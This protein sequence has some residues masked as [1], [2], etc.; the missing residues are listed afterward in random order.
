MAD[1]TPAQKPYRELTPEAF[2]FGIGLGMLMTAAFVYI[3]LKLGFSMPGSTVA[4]ILGFAVL[5]GV[6]RKGTIVEN[7][8]NQTIASAVNNASAGVAF[9]L[10][11][12]FILSLND[13]SVR[14]E[15]IPAL[16]AAI[17]GSFLGIIFIIPLRKQMIEFDRLKF[18]TGIAVAAILKAPGAAARQAKLLAGGFG[19]AAAF[20][21]LTALHVIP[22]EYPMGVWLGLP[23]H[24]PIAVGI[25]FAIVGAGLLAGKGGLPFVFGG[26][27]AWWVVSPIAVGQ[28][29]VPSPEDMRLAGEPEGYGAWST[30]GVVFS[31]MLRPL[32]IGILIGG[33][34]SGVIASFPAIKAAVGSLSK[35]AAMAKAG[36]SSDELSPKVLY[37]G[38]GGSVVVLFLA[39]MLSADEISVG[40]SLLIAVVGTVWLALA[41]LVVAQATGMTD[42]SPISGMSLI[43]VTLMF[44]LSGGSA[45]ASIVLG[46]AVSIGIG[47][48]ADMMIDLKAGHLVGALPRRQQL[49]QLAVGWVGV[50]VAIGVVYLLWNTEG[51]GPLNPN[52]SAPQGTA[53]AAVIGGLQQ[54]AAPLDKY[55]AGAVVGLGLGIFPISGAAVLVGL[56]MY[57]PF[58]ITLTYGVGCFAA[59]GLQRVKGSR[60][61]G[62]TLV[63]V[64]AG[65]IIGEALT[66]LFMVLGK[67]AVGYLTVGG[68]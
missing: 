20:H 29:W 37:T 25:S 30:M 21:V 32:G 26:M 48:C 66:N 15:F 17:G 2:I 6:L 52:L 44:F 41:G 63:P 47:Q 22:E 56:A 8:I 39:A 50:P 4:A 38:I 10:P 31:Q 58:Y 55:V 35:A 61:I 53:L 11:A 1:S 3:S 62:S 60:W 23:A 7:N 67:L 64:A 46:I 43:G 9:T 49:A 13:P 24:I 33:A 12:L 34:L 57:L 65:F 40:Q 51:F 19:V 45:V 14:I 18:P 28:G 36:G 54:G 16:L 27:L 5:R 68:A 59:M 42:I